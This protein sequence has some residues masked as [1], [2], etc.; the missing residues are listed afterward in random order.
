LFA[1]NQLLIAS[2]MDEARVGCIGASFAHFAQ[3]KTV[4]G[5]DGAGSEIETARALRKSKLSEQERLIAGLLA[6]THLLDVIQNFML[7]MQA[8]GQTVRSVRRYQ[9]G[10]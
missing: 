6:P 7:F 10:R 2:C 1:T 4:V 3:W 5:P 9:S 8:G